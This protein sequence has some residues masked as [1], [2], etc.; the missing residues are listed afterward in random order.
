MH[1]THDIHS[2]LIACLLFNC[3]ESFHGYHECAIKQVKEG[4]REIG[5]CVDADAESLDELLKKLD[6]QA[7]QYSNTRNAEIHEL[8]RKC[9]QESIDVMPRQFSTLAEARILL[10]IIIRR[11]VHWLAST[12][13]L[14]DFSE[15][16]EPW[17]LFDV[18]PS[19]KEKKKTLH[20]FERWRQAY[21]PLL[22]A[23]K[24]TGRGESFVLAMALRLHWLAG[25]LT[26]ASNASDISLDSGRF[27]AELEELVSVSGILLVEAMKAEKPYNFAFDV[28]V[29]VPLTT[30]GWIYRHRALRRNVIALL[31]QSP[32]REGVW[33]GVVMGKVLA[34]LAREEEEGLVD[35]EYVPE[36]A[37]ARMIRM[38][39]DAKSKVAHV[40]CFKPVQGPGCEKTTK[41]EI[42]IPW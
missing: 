27:V 12:V 21:G 18:N 26:V 11:S 39:F 20:E 13:H 28:Q 3:F 38:R 10:E 30:V 1:P 23:E 9:G 36:H 24:K 8:Y 42:K 4:L 35:S 5:D 37:T 2:T 40:S 6:E 7:V 25:Y 14:H 31:R 41:V 22:E 15:A 34:W 16:L 17:S 33:D 32:R 29:I 19:A